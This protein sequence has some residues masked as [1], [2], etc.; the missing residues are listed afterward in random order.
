[1]VEPEEIYFTLEEKLDNCISHLQD[2]FA[3][4]SQNKAEAARAAGKFDDEIVPVT[5]KVKKAEVG[6]P[7]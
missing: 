4:N 1:M 7:S 3:A 6:C 5:I 2:T